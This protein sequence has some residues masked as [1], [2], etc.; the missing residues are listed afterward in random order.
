MT[1]IIIFKNLD[2][3]EYLKIFD[4]KSLNRLKRL[5]NLDY[6]RSLESLDLDS[7]ENF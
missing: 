7:L 3:F 6:V 5:E 2:H 1:Y 4:L